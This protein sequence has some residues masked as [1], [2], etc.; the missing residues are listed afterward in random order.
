MGERTEN[1][2]PG[3]IGTTL[4]RLAQTIAQR[5]EQLPEASYTTALF[6]K[7][8]DFLHKK[9]VEEATEVILAAA[10]HDHDHLRYEAGDLLYHLLVLLE[11]EGVS[12]AELAG[13]LDARM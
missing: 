2:V 8:G 6:T 12:L 7:D 4:T 10:A 3:D 9:V 1:V 5:H 13:E 11:R